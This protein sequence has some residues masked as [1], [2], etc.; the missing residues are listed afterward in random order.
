MLRPSLVLRRSLSTA[1]VRKLKFHEATLLRK[2]DFINWKSDQSVRENKI[3][4]RYHVQ[5]RED[6]HTYNKVCGLITK[7][8][9]Q[10]KGLHERDPVRIEVTDLL[11]EKVRERPPRS[12]LRSSTAAHT[13]TSLVCCARSSTAWA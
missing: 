11:L 2:L 1:M 4:R 7:L 13:L 8:V 9:T 10:L 6:Y 12:P 5:D 3:L